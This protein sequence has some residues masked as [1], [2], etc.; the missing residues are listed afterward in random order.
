MR[1]R[2][3]K[4]LCLLVSMSV[5]VGCVSTPTHPVHRDNV[6]DP[7]TE[8]KEEILATMLRIHQDA[9]SGNVG[10]LRFHHLNSEKFSKLGPRKPERQNFEETTESEASFFSSITD[11]TI[12]P[13]DLK[14]DVFGDVAVMTYFPHVTFKKDGKLM[15][16]NGRQTVVFVKTTDGWLIA[17]EQGTG[18]KLQD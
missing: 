8:A 17:H 6:H 12:D 7:F 18:T 9:E 16:G 3:L 15:K 14:V 10:A 11:F 1:F 5:C 13:R 2:G 4:L